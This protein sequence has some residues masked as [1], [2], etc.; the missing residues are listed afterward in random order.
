MSP[1]AGLAIDAGEGLPDAAAR[2][3]AH[4]RRYL[5]LLGI[6]EGHAAAH[7]TEEALRAAQQ[8]A[9]WAW[10]QHA[11]IH[12]SP[13]LERLVRGLAPAGEPWRQPARRRPDR[14]PPRRPAVLHVLSQA[15]PT[16][17][18]TRWSDRIIRAD[19]ARAHSVLLTSQ[20]ALPVPAWLAR[21]VAASGGRLEVLPP[22]SL[23]ARVRAVAQ[24]AGGA[25]LVL[26]NH[27]PNDVAA[28]AALADPRRRPPVATLNHADHAFWLGMGAT[29][30]LVDFRR[31]GQDLALRRRGADGERCALLPLPVDIPERAAHEDPNRARVRDAMGIGRDEIVLLTAGS[32]WKFDPGGLLGAP[33]FPSVLAPIVAADPRLRLFALGPRPEGPWAEAARATGGRI[34]ALGTRTDYAD[35]T[36]AADLYLDP[37]PMGSLYSLL[38]PAALGV[39]AVSLAQWPATAAVLMADAPGLDGVRPVAPDREAFEDLVRGLVDD[40]AARH[41][42]GARLRASVAGAHA[43]EGWLAAFDAI[44]TGATAARD[45]VIAS[46]P[47]LDPGLDEPVTDLLARGLAWIPERVP[48][49]PERVTVH[50]PLGGGASRGQP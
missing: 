2:V 22:G 32:G 10:L 6:A 16:G 42:L 11:G 24:A 45:R 36:L 9:G 34:Q 8:A 38:E 27:H 30:L 31:T 39:A 48:P 49:P 20:G 35:F 46:P 5:E 19:P 33:S 37:F 28:V 43:G 25:D 21:S 26:A 44:A 17:G 14:R 50:L 1:A 23:A 40:A 4:H 3:L 13:R 15:Y 18:H 41:G 29:D 12:A 47:G 7:R